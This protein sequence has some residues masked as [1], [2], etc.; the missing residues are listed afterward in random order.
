MVRKGGFQQTPDQ[1]AGGADDRGTG[2]RS[3][4]MRDKVVEIP[5]QLMVA[6]MTGMRVGEGRDR[7]EAGEQEETQAGGFHTGNLAD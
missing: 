6:I 7:E 1:P 4:R 2:E 5:D 3:Q